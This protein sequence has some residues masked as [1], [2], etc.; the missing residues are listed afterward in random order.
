M[1]AGIFLKCKIYDKKMFGQVLSHVLSLLGLL[2][3]RRF[4]SNLQSQKLTDVIQEEMIGH[5][6]CNLECQCNGHWWRYM[7]LVVQILMYFKE[8][9]SFLILLFT[10]LVIFC[11]CFND[12]NHRGISES[13][14]VLSCSI[15]IIHLSDKM[16]YL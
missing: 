5:S 9:N 12:K 4:L 2:C 8:R 15:C 3:R 13:A 1:S 14:R 10:F 16:S 11:C 6:D 7:L